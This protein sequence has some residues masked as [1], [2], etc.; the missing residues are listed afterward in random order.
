M[1]IV[2]VVRF[3][4]SEEDEQKML[5]QRETLLAAVRAHS[6]GLQRAVLTKIDEKTWMDL[7]HWD[8]EESLTK[9][10]QARLPEAVASF[11]MVDLID[12]TMGRVVTTS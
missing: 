4:I 11:A 3:T 10:Q 6:T 2:N 9:V 5:A 8:S 1:D 12:G 7:W